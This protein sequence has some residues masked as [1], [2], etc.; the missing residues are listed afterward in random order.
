M[1]ELQETLAAH[2]EAF[3]HIASG[4]MD[5]KDAAKTMGESKMEA[6]NALRDQFKT[7]EA[8][9]Q[10]SSSGLSAVKFEM[11]PPKIH[12]NDPDWK[13]FMLRFDNVMACH[14]YTRRAPPCARGTGR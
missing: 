1:A 11:T 8:E 12:D 9:R 2:Q 3:K 6:L 4:L 13:G 10:G 14:A 5:F 7:S